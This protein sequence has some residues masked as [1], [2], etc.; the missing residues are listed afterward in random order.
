MQINFLNDSSSIFTGADPFEV[1]DYVNRHVGSHDLKL[2]KSRDSSASMK[3]AKIGNMDFCHLQYGTRARVISEGLADVYHVQFILRGHCR[4]DLHRDSLSL[5][6][7]HVLLINPEDPIDLTYSDD[8]EK[9]ILKI[10]SSMFNEA[11]HEHNWSTLNGQVKFNQ[12]PYQFE[13]LQSLMCLLTLV[14]QEAESGMA[15]PQMLQHYSRVVT[16][17]LMTLL[18]HNI[19]LETAST[20]SVSF[21]RLVRYIEQNI[22]RDVSAEELAQYA[23]LSLRSLYLL[24][25]KNARTTPKNFIRQRKLEQVYATLM[26]PASKAANITAVAL[27]YGFTHLGRFSEFYKSTFGM[28]PSESLKTR[29]TAM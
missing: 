21:E 4:F 7:G 25:E 17:K 22:K 9:F 16:S 28:L 6:A 10:P 12:V 11:C 3:H 26:D 18:K 8:C 24:F 20:H 1:S 14:C 15:T 5:S 2:C 23:H 19:R 27:D 13:E 29:Q